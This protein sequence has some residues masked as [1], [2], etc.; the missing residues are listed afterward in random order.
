MTQILVT[1]ASGLLGSSVVR[2]AVFEHEVAATY[3][4]RPVELEGADCFQVDL[5]DERQYG[6]IT[7][8]DPDIIVH[9][10][11]LT[12]VDLCERNPET[13]QK[14]NVELTKKLLTLADTLDARFV[15][16]ST[17]AVFDGEQG[18][19]S[20]ADETNPIN[21]YGRTKLAAERAVQRAAADSV[22]VR[23]S[24][25]GWNITDGQ[26]LAEWILET[27]RTQAELPAFEDA[28]FSPIYTGDLSPRLLELAFSDVGGVV[29]VAGS[30]R[31]SKLEFAELLAEVFD[32]DVKLIV[33]T[34]ADDVDFDA[35][36][37]QDLSLAVARA[38]EYLNAP[39]PTV[40]DGLEHMRDDEDE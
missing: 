10:A 15:Y 33:P 16:I 13:A 38:Q 6:P 32:L 9:C 36:R 4:T 12:D 39:L 28:Y 35:P 24:I 1:G 3:F 40:V 21:V 23:T 22:I 31:C 27:L 17:D 5:T 11:A 25:Y 8:F 19:Y 2:E 37:G 29:H 20:E 34:S 30:Q 14:H 26:S 18:R 7:A